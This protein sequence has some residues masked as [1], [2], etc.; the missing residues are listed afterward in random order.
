MI[1]GISN[2]RLYYKWPVCDLRRRAHVGILHVQI[3][4]SCLLVVNALD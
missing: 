4:I 2:G 3:L 1:G